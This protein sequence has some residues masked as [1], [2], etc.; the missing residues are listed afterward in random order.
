VRFAIQSVAVLTVLCSLPGAS[1]LRGAES[2]A[3]DHSRFRV[4]VSTSTVDGVNDNDARAAIKMWGDTFMKMAGLEGINDQ[5]VL[6]GPDQLLQ[7]VRGGLVDA[8]S[9]TAPEYPPMAPYVDHAL[10]IGDEVEMGQGDE[11]FLLVHQESG[12]QSIADLRGRNMIVQKGAKTCLARIWLETLASGSGLGT[13]DELL[14]RITA[15][16]KPAMVVLPVFFRRADAGVVTQAEFAAMC[17]LN[18]QLGR[19][20]R[21]LA[22]SPKVIHSFLVFHRDCPPL[23]KARLKTAMLGIHESASGRQILTLWQCRRLVAADTS[24]LRGTLELMASYDRIRAR[25]TAAKK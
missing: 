17:E 4:A 15:E 1:P 24:V 9:I 6:S 8:F 20:L 22:V 11:Y 7:E 2:I 16:T 18:P 14:G 23:F 3:R 21:V 19:K 5:T 25:K 12:I 10:V 13:A